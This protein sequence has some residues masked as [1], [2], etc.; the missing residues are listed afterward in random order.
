ML[1]HTDSWSLG[2]VCGSEFTSAHCLW[3]WDQIYIIELLAKVPPFGLFLLTLMSG[4]IISSTCSAW[5][6][7]VYYTA[8]LK[9]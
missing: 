2:D 8:K 6:I 5:Q 4:Q 7:G 9:H 1:S 3:C